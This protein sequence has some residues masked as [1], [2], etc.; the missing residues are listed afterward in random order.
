M[1]KS[2]RHNRHDAISI[3][4]VQIERKAF[5]LIELFIVISIISL[6]LALILA[7]VQRVRSAA[8]RLDCQ[9][10]LRNLAISL[11]QHHDA[12]GSLPSGFN[13]LLGKSPYPFSGWQV[14][15]LPYIEQ[16]AV[17][18]RAQS[19][20]GV[21]RTVSGI[22]GHAGLSTIIPAYICPL[23]PRIQVPV[24][25]EGISV[26]FTS[27]LGS[28]GRDCFKN[29][30]VLFMDSRIRFADISDGLSSTLLL[31]ERPPSSDLRRGWW[32]AGKGQ[33]QTGSTEMILGTLESNHLIRYH[34]CSVLQPYPFSQGNF[35]DPCSVFHFWSPHDGGGNFANSDGAVRFFRYSSSTIL[36]ALSTRSGGEATSFD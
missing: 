10:R 1:R 11:H 32:Y 15:V 31:G 16:D 3:S 28:C 6:T 24:L 13:S 30:G 22:T 36:P 14:A 33:L 2:Q 29:D 34:S 17:F 9:N 4:N 5:S 18:R 12:K 20:F 19:D 7:G 23:D 27:Y 35:E 26:A 21:D 25:S 8:I